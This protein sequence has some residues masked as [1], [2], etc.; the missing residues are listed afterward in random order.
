VVGEQTRQRRHTTPWE[1]CVTTEK[2]HTGAKPALAID[3][4]SP[5]VQS[6]QG[7]GGH[8][9]FLRISQAGD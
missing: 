8:T 2:N 5:P 4:L 3:V 9:L 6:S 1:A 7:Q